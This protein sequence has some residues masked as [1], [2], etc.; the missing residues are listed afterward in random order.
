MHNSSL[1]PLYEGH[2][3]KATVLEVGGRRLLLSARHLLAPFL[4]SLRLPAHAVVLSTASP[5]VFIG[6]GHC[7]LRCRSAAGQLRLTRG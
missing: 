4:S 3:I 7:I 2:M 5:A 6:I 1:T